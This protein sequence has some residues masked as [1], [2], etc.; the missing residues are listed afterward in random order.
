MRLYIYIIFSVLL[1]LL[2]GCRSRPEGVDYDQWKEALKAPRATSA[3]NVLAPPGFEVDLIRTA[4]KEEGSWVSLEFD[5]KGR[6]LVGREGPGIL[7]MTLPKGRFGRVNIELVNDHLNECRGLLWAYDSLYVNANNSKGFYRLR[8]TT[9]DDFFDQVTLLK[10]TGGAVGHGRNSLALGPDGFIYIA[11]GND[12]LLPED[13]S[14]SPK[15]TYRHY[16]QDRLL[17]CEWNQVL[18]NKGVKPPAGHIIRTDRHGNRWEMIAGGFRNPYGL[19]F[20]IDNEL[21]VF[22]ADM[23]WDEGTPWYRPTRINHVVSGGDYGWRQGTDKW[24]EY[25]PD[26]LPSNLN[27]GLGSPTAIAF[28]TSS[29]FPQIYRNSL[30]ILDWAYGKIFTVSLMPKGASYSG[31]FNEFVSGRPLNVTGADFGP[32][33]SLYFV[34]GGRRTK[35]GLYRVRYTGNHKAFPVLEDLNKSNLLESKRMRELRFR[36]E[37]Y[38]SEQSV[39]A[40]GFA[41][42]Y[43]DHDDLWI[44]HAAR[45]ALE[46]QPESGWSF[47]ALTESNV[48]KALMALMA[49]SRVG[50]QKIKPQILARLNYLDWE[51]LEPKWQL[52]ALRAYH[53]AFTRMGVVRA[54]DRRLI[55]NKIAKASDLSP[56]LRM[57]VSR[58]MIHLNAEGMIPQLLNYVVNAQSQEERFFYLFHMRHISDGWS[59]AHRR[60]YFSWLKNMNKEQSDIHFQGFMKHIIADA[61][62]KVP[63][64]DRGEYDAM[65]DRQIEVSLDKKLVDRVEREKW[66]MESFLNLDKSLP[67]GDLVNGLRVLKEA[68]CLACHTF[69][70]VGQAIGPDL[71]AIGSRFDAEAILE[72]IIEPSRVIADKYRNISVTTR[73]GEL[74]EGRLLGER[75]KSLLISINSSNLSHVREVKLDVLATRSD[76]SFSPMPAGLLNSFTRKEVI[77]LLALLRSGPQK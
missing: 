54:D 22:D 69:N 57:E 58:L 72:S 39:E 7:R 55:I 5:G 63:P 49:L 65:F 59:E 28:G 18:F 16:E 68:A 38:H 17:P 36:L 48:R 45:V 2:I 8:D 62:A 4:T 20:N 75:D 25:F 43:L 70:G 40:I 19:A 47:P 32:D 12:V 14:A 30:F 13:F 23:E 46:Y 76:S 41:W 60:A 27:I 29:N 50:E 26:S 44:R 6:L 21:F 24:P 52:V 42:R 3:R 10:K 77:D 56:A 64:V 73:K 61:L 9:G 51:S 1:V 33:G 11:H 66:T 15:S 34:T 31:E 74:I 53:L 67:K 35:S 71:T 37:K